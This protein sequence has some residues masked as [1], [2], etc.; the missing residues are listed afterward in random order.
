LVLKNRETCVFGANNNLTTLNF[1]NYNYLLE[2][3]EEEEEEGYVP[4][5][6]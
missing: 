3:E 2:E 4:D 5:V 1:N 6:V